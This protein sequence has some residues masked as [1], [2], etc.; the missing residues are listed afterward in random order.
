MK[1]LPEIR[2][3]KAHCGSFDSGFCWSANNPYYSGHYATKEK[4]AS[5]AVKSKRALATK[6]RNSSSPKDSKP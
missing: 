5:A 2:L 1:P 6:R 3:M 4:A